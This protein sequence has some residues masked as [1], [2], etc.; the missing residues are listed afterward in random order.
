[1]PPQIPSTSTQ[2]D[3]TMSLYHLAAKVI[4]RSTGRCAT[5]AAAYRAG[6][7]IF[8]VRTGLVFDFSRRREVDH[9]F[10]RILA[11]EDSPAWVFDR[12]ELW[13]RVEAAEKRKDAQVTR[14]IELALPV[15][16]TPEEQMALVFSF[17]QEQFVA[18]GM[19]ADIS[20]HVNAGN[21]HVHILLTMRPL[22]N[23][24]FS[25]KKERGWNDVALLLK[26]REAW[27]N[28]Q[29]AAFESRMVITRVD[30]RSLRE[31]GINRPPQKHVGSLVWNLAIKGLAW[32]KEVVDA[33]RSRW[34]SKSQ[35]HEE[36]R[37]ESTARWGQSTAIH[38]LD[39]HS[40]RNLFFR[41]IRPEGSRC[42]GSQVVDGFYG[43]AAPSVGVGPSHDSEV[44]QGPA[45]LPSSKAPR[46]SRGR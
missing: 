9:A 19:I 29:N 43:A 8:D 34:T 33:K 25:S 41:I 10:C 4:S 5:A 26:W 35:V 36:V 11:P 15:E 16:F 14:E 46:Q 17:V 32:A 45:E 18:R 28:A 37:R 22:V 44:E 13:N 23:G 31:Q 38:S 12:H 1:M 3:V 39:Q 6:E 7:R 21:P 20:R 27:A 24:Q 30:H 40:F 42:P 2:F